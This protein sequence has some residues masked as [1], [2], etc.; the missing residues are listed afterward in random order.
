MRN[1]TLLYFIAIAFILSCSPGERKPV[2]NEGMTGYS[3][4]P[5]LDSW[6][7]YYHLNLSDFTDSI[8]GVE[9]NMYVY[10]WD[11]DEDSLNVLKEFY[12]YS[13]DSVYCI[14]LDSYGKLIERDSAG[15]LFVLVMI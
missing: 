12:I 6:L 14:D 5:Q 13:P 3:K 2:K 15:Q 11:L 1:T 4:Y 7:N 10:N 8:S 9:Y